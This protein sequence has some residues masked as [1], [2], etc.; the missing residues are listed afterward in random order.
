MCVRTYKIQRSW[1]VIQSEKVGKVGR[2]QVMKSFV[3]QGVRLNICAF[4]L[5]SL[6]PPPI[7]M[8][9]L[10]PQ[11][12]GNQRWGLWEVLRVAPSRMGFAP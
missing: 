11:C 4:V 12:D 6:P 7:H 1:R 2:D 8:L 5:P 3:N 9:K 10:N